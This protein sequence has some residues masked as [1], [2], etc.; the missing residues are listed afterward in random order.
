[1]FGTQPQHAFWPPQSWLPDYNTII[2]PGVSASVKATRSVYFSP[3]KG[4][5]SPSS[6]YTSGR[7]CQL[8]V[9]DGSPCHSL[10]KS[11]FTSSHTC[12]NFFAKLTSMGKQT[13]LGAQPNSS[14]LYSSWNAHIQTSS[15]CSAAALVKFNAWCSF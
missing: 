6:A 9:I 11:I 15:T 7:S 5:L 4:T 8:P 2:P 13:G 3:W 14:K 10:I 1:M 12:P